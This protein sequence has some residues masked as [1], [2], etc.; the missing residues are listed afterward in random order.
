MSK[1]SLTL[2]ACKV[3]H[4]PTHDAARVKVHDRCGI[5]PA[6]GCPDAGKVCGPLLVRSSSLEIP[7]RWFG[8]MWLSSRL[9]LFAGSRRRLRLACNLTRCISRITRLSPQLSP[10]A[11]RSSQTRGLLQQYAAQPRVLSAAPPDQG[12]E[13]GPAP[14]M[15]GRRKK[16][17]PSRRRRTDKGLRGRAAPDPWA[18]RHE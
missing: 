1:A 16:P 15:A 14:G 18:R 8:A 11:R 13:V 9:T 5:Q 12:K 6:F 2:L 7:C 3:S 10:M 17:R 4:G